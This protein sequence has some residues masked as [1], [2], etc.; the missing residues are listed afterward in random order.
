MTEK[1]AQII[2]VILNFVAVILVLMALNE[3]L[4]IF[5]ALKVKASRIPFDGGVYYLLL[6]SV[7]WLMSIIQ[8]YGK[9]N[10][11]S[12]WYKHASKIIITWF[13][14]CLIL[15]NVI[16]VY[17]KN[18]LSGAGYTECVSPD[19]IP[20]ATNYESLIFVLGPC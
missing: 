14:F 10:K 16:P 7:F 17:L 5:S 13:V 3:F 15:A 11:Q 9:R 4:S 20:R 19:Y 2:F 6:M 18:K 1:N 12:F 8:F